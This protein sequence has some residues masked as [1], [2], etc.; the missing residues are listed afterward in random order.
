MAKR[1]GQSRNS[2][3]F[4]FLPKSLQM[5]TVATKLKDSCSLGKK[6]MKN[7]DSILKS[8]G[9]ADK[10][11]HSLS[12]SFSNSH[13]CMW[14]LDCKEGWP[15]KDWCIWTVVLEKT[16]DS[17]LDY[18]QIQP[19][20]PKGN[21]WIFIGR[22]DAEAPIIWP[23]DAK[24]WLIGNDLDAGKDSGQDK[25]VATEDEIVG[26]RHWL[27]E[28][29]L[30]QAQEDGEGQGSLACCSSWDHKESDMS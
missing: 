19:I 8:R 24:S 22:N 16:L 10:C 25:K 21:Q 7:L 15:P 13:A 4:Y 17:S 14:E 30:E 20:N 26:C 12:Y 11:P 28:H 27:N 5:V 6:Y 3:R 2:D 9:F 29:K 1:W 18:K 23:P